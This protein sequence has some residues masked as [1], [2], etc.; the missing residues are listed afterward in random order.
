MGN[1]ELKKKA[2]IDNSPRYSNY[3]S[4]S[5]EEGELSSYDDDDILDGSASPFIKCN[6][7]QEKPIEAERV[8][9]TRED[10]KA[11][12]LVPSTKSGDLV[13]LPTRATLHSNHHKSFEKNRGSFVPFVISF[14]DEDSGSDREESKQQNALVGKGKSLL[15]RE[16]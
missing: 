16:K 14:S 8:T 15:L 7:L 6:A 11:G 2:A 10:V 12:M 1:E 4:E 5:R 9:S 13:D 3:P